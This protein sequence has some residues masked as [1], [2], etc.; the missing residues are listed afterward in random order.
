MECAFTAFPPLEATQPSL[1]VPGLKDGRFYNP[2]FLPGGRDFL[3]AFVPQQSQ[4]AQ[5][6][7]ATLRDGKAVD[8]TLLFKNDTAAAYT[9]AGGGRIL[10][11]RNDNLYSQKL[12]RKARKLTGEAELVQEA[13]A[14]AVGISQRPILRFRLGDH[15]LAQRD[16][17][18][19]AVDG[20]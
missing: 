15:R 8:P 6:Y 11:V 13:V 20:L 4:E 12:D 2:E 17:G 5:I 3:F 18:S 9:P 10:F 16:G 19:I 14:S 1:E 7:L